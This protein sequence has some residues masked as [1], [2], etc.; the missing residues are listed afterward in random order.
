MKMTV[1]REPPLHLPLVR[2]AKGER[3]PAT[4]TTGFSWIPPTISPERDFQRAFMKSKT[5]HGETNSTEGF[6]TGRSTL[7]RKSTYFNRLS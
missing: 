3:N 6:K 5:N 1:R 2:F 4:Q 7:P